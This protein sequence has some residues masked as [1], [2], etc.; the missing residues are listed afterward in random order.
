MIS[1]RK[2]GVGEPIFD[3]WIDT[4]GWI[5]TDGSM[6]IGLTRMDMIDT[7]DQRE[8]IFSRRSILSVVSIP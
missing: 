5:W 6:V 3:Q 2:M 1:F 4:I 7:I 8:K